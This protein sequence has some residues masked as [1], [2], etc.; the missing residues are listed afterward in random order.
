MFLNFFAV[1]LNK[2]SLLK[3]AYQRTK[4]GCAFG[5]ALMIQSGQCPPLKHDW[6]SR[7]TA[8]ER[9]DANSH[10]HQLQL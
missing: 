7:S 9:A 8:L 4:A 5:R 6:Q 1:V 2:T 10:D 3:N